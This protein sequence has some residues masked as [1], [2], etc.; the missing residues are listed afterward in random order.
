MT[1]KRT[2]RLAAYLLIA[3]LAAWAA[4]FVIAGVPYTS[5]A[6][7]PPGQPLGP[8]QTVYMPYYPALYS[9]LVLL[10]VI[11]G[12]IR[13]QWLPLAWIG[14]LLHLAIGVLLIFSF[15][16]LYIGVTGL[17]VTLVSLIQWEASGRARW[18]LAAAAGAALL[19]LIGVVMLGTVYGYPLLAAGLILCGLVL[20]LWTSGLKEEQRVL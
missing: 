18:F 12:L 9:P 16:I 11:V 3:A 5:Y 13:D 2:A 6:E 4:Y 20:F 1:I 15:G 7:V 10:L 8:A 17:L 14:L 19:L